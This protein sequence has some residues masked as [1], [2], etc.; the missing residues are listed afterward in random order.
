MHF[1]RCHPSLKATRRG[2]VVGLNA[3]HLH[4]SDIDGACG[5][6]CVMSALL[7]LGV[8]DRHE[9]SEISDARGPAKS[10]WRVAKRKYFVG[11]GMGELQSML[12]PFDEE[13]EVRAYRKQ[14]IVR[15]LD[16]L[17]E[18]GVAILAIS[19]QRFSHW[20]LAIGVSGFKPGSDSLP[21]KLLILDPGHNPVPLAPWNATLKVQ[22]G[23]Q[24]RRAYE[25]PT[26][27]V[28]VDLGSVLTIKRSAEKNR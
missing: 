6:H 3:V 19:N 17:A 1:Y 12:L 14:G 28:L 26:S 16:V 7:I 23:S 21:S 8:L 10:M 11:A 25:M 13:I 22:G 20:V 5:A 2:P 9:L 24:N 4:Q 15:T 27:K 18:F